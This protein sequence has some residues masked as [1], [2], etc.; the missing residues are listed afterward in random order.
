M[1]PSAKLQSPGLAIAP[2]APR[3]G[4]LLAGIYHDIGLAAVAQGLKID[5]SG[6]EDET[7]QAVSRGA[8]YIQL[9]PRRQESGLPV[10]ITR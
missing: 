3:S 2:V 1:Q 6:L 4:R 9:M 7:A 8:R 5:V 10:S